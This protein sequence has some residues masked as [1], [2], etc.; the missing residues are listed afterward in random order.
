MSEATGRRT[1]SELGAV[2]VLIVGL[3]RE[4]TALAR[5]LTEGEARVTV[6]D[7]K[8]A[9]ELAEYLSVLSGRPVE[10]SLG[11]HPLALLDVTDIVFVSPGVPLEIPLLAE[12]RL[13]GI[14]LS[15]ETR[16]FT[17]RC[18]APIVGVTGSSGKTTTTAFVGAILKAAGRKVWVGGNIGVPLLGHLEEIDRSDTVVMEL[19]SFQLEF[20]GSSTE[21]SNWSGLPEGIYCP[22]GWSPRIAGILNITPNHLDRHASMEA[23]I[24]AKSQI[25]VNQG[26]DDIAVLGL[27]NEETRRIGESGCIQSQIRWFS[28]EQ[29]VDEGA[30]LLG[31]SLILRSDA[32]ERTIC[33]TGDLQ[34][35]GWHNVEN[36]LA[37]FALAGAAGAPAEAMHDVATTF[38]GVE[39][40]LEL[41]GE[42]EGVP[43]YNDS[44]ATTPERTV[45]ALCALREPII[46]LAGGRDK[47]LPWAEMAAL[48]WKRVRQLILFGEAAE[49]IEAEMYRAKPEREAACTI[50]QAGTLERAVE[51][52]AASARTGDTVLL[53]PGGTSFDAFNDFEERGRRFRQLFRSLE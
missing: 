11:A 25:V 18:P 37:A 8:E 38:T 48:T 30:F 32:L 41:L 44:I 46:L 4:G 29:P 33:R 3:A 20:F 16:L 7:I 39:H 27:D 17:S 40:R 35:I 24:A 28:M 6:T 45:A 22:E 23:Y 1:G 19:S 9:D 53:S 13:R 42:R 15:T 31:D 5:F 47:H 51:I 14:P 50:V 34:L 10:Y 49:L 12:A 36:A 43:W 2:K 52:A 21:D 26:Q